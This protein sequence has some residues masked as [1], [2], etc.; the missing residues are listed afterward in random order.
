M[1]ISLKKDIHIISQLAVLHHYRKM[2]GVTIEDVKEELWNFRFLQL[3][4]FT[5]HLVEKVFWIILALSGMI[6]FVY[7]MSTI[8][9][10]WN[11][12]KT[13]VSKADVQ[14]SDIKT[15]A[16]TFCSK[17]ATKYGIAERL[18]N[19]LDPKKTLKSEHL[20]WIK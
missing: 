5:S 15:P 10:V 4:K 1:A 7:Y 3:A 17:S 11:I 14:L 9:M 13:V 16:L 18:G 12:N 19:Y 2:V 6:W 8:F 20:Q